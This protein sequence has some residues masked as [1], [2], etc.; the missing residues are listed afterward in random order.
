MSDVHSNTLALEMQAISHA[1]Q[2]LMGELRDGYGER[3]RRFVSFFIAQLLNSTG[4]IDCARENLPLAMADTTRQVPEETILQVLENA[5]RYR[6]E[7][8]KPRAQDRDEA[9]VNAL[10]QSLNDLIA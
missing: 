2:R 8:M 5:R 4:S 6:A 9:A 7:A 3:T 10:R 1:A